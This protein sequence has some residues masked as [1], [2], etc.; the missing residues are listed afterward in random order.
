MFEVVGTYMD[1]C[2]TLGYW[3]FGML[4]RGEGYD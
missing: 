3:C 1:D 2:W 4:L